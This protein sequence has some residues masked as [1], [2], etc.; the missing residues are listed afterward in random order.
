MYAFVVNHWFL[1]TT[2]TTILGIVGASLLSANPV[3]TMLVVRNVI[4][5]YWREILIALIVVAG[6]MYVAGL[7]L[8]IAEQAKQ[9]E[10]DKINITTLTA[11]NGKLEASIKDANVMIDKFDQF[12]ADTKKQ[13]AGLNKDVAARNQTLAT[14]IQDILREKKP[15]TCEEAIN[16]LINHGG[17]K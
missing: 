10:I 7:K 6:Y 12:T 15:Q 3:G 9:M 13:F 11:N 2:V 4:K 16:Y 17:A 1:I 8:T 14:Q 5:T